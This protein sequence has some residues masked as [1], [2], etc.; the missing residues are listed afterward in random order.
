VT[1]HTHKYGP[2]NECQLTLHQVRFHKYCMQSY[3]TDAG[4]QS[5]STTMAQRTNVVVRY[6]IV[7][8]VVICV[9]KSGNGCD[10]NGIHSLYIYFTRVTKRNVIFCYDC[11]LPNLFINGS[12]QQFVNHKSNGTASPITLNVGEH[13]FPSK[14][15][16]S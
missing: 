12:Q 6:A 1:A 7:S 3:R 16:E 8:I 10:V 2:T 11:T 13:K 5:T 14:Y 9:Y 15:S 4:T